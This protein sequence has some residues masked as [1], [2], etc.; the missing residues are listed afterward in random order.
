[1][2]NFHYFYMGIPNLLLFYITFQWGGIDI[3]AA[4]YFVFYLLISGSVLMFYYESDYNY[5]KKQG[6]DVYEQM[7]N[8]KNTWVQGGAALASYM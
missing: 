1:M 6:F 5:M 8:F 2:I 4:I 3:F 7:V